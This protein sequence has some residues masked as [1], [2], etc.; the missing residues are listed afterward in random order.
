M[1]FGIQYLESTSM[2]SYALTDKHKEA[3]ADP[4]A[5]ADAA[6]APAGGGTAA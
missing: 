2:T 1:E 3:Q 4:N 6:S 5:S